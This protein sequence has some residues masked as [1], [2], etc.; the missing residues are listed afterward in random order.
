MTPGLE[1]P[2]CAAELADAFPTPLYLVGGFVRDGLL[3]YD[4][5]DIDLASATDVDAAEKA[6]RAA[7]CAI[8]RKNC[9]TMTLTAKKDGRA[10]EYSTFRSDAYGAGHAP[11][12]VKRLETAEA[13]SARRDFA[14]NS[15]YCD[16]SSGEIL[17]PQNG[18]SDLRLRRVRAAGSP[19]RVFASD[20]DRIMRLA[21]IASELGFDVEPDTL[22]AAKRNARLIDDIS[23]DR[24]RA[25]LD[26]ILT[27][28]EKHGIRNAHLR[29][30]RLLD[31]IGALERIL[32]ELTAGK[33]MLQ[34]KDFHKHDVFD[35]ALFSAAASDPSIRLAALLHD[36]GKPFVKSATGR[37]RGHE[38]KGA[39]VAREILT[40]LGYPRATIEEVSRLIACHMFNLRGDESKSAIRG[41]I[42]ENRDIMEKLHL[43]RQADRI[44]GGFSAGASEPDATYAEYRSM[45]E[46]RIPLS[47]SELR[48]DGRDLLDIP[49]VPP[50]ERGAALNALLRETALRD[51][52]P[53]DREQQLEFLRKYKRR[54]Q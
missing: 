46:R 11:I 48:V 35:H 45:L 28:D 54:T 1:I 53:P 23:V 39:A 5:A 37:Y 47:V 49:T 13:D 9:A 14:I 21:R 27:G 44:G 30:L 31:E 24:V 15:I 32:P 22:R 38:A 3:G 7:G 2:R 50:S 19:E 34:R 18:L 36:I 52:A 16:V 42:L 25:E 51:E 26:K 29:G 4:C 20:G 6:F 40:R 17:D 41:F 12:S 43:L 8:L 33:G 10:I